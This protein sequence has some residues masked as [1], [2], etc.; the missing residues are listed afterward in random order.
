MAKQQFFGIKYPF[1]NKDF[2]NFFLD[3]NQDE[4][5]YVKS[6]IMHV[7]FTPKGQRIREPEFGTDLIRYIFEPSDDTTWE[8][9]KNEISDAVQR[10]V[11][12]VIINDIQVAKTEDNDNAIYVRIDY[13]VKQGNKLVKDTILTEI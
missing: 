10:Y 3:V 9:V 12:N 5:D 4:T 13:S 8:G 6:Q 11:G 7:I 1:V 2:Q